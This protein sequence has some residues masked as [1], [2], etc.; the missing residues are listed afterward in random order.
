MVL[1]PLHSALQRAGIDQHLTKMRP[2]LSYADVDI[3]KCA[4][5]RGARFRVRWACT[6][7]Q[8]NDIACDIDSIDVY[9]AFLPELLAKI[10][11]F[12][13]VPFRMSELLERFLVLCLY[14]A[15]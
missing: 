8:W 1:V 13:V 7:S 10:T 4:D 9:G 5:V 14:S 3:K 12:K 6:I 15:K 11:T 2:I